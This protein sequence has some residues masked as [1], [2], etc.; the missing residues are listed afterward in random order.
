MKTKQDRLDC[1]L[2]LMN[3]NKNVG[4]HYSNFIKD[5]NNIALIP[6]NSYEEFI[7]QYYSN[8]TNKSLDELI[9]KIKKNL[10]V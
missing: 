5:M 9:I 7:Q 8:L 3:T 2:N 10:A 1:I 4:N 6:I